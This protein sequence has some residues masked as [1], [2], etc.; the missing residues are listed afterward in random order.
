VTF[1]DPASVD[2]VL[3]VSKHELDS[4]TVS[5][6]VPISPVYLHTPLLTFAAAIVILAI[7]STLDKMYLY[8][9]SPNFLCYILLD[10]SI[11]E[12]VTNPNWRPACHAGHVYMVH[13]RTS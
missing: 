2:K 4:K 8:I 10:V 3:A 1:R 9:N 13:R 5:T 6:V 11:S 12:S 7:F